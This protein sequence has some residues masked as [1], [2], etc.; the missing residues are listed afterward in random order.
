M[1]QRRI[2]LRLKIQIRELRIN[3]PEPGAANMFCLT[4]NHQ[5]KKARTFQFEEEKITIG[6]G[7]SCDLTI[8]DQSID[9]VQATITL[10]EDGYVLRNISPNPL[11]YLNYLPAL[12]TGLYP[13]DEIRV[14]K[15]LLLFETESVKE[16]EGSGRETVEIVPE[17]ELETTVGATLERNDSRLIS[18]EESGADGGKAAGA[19]EALYRVGLIIH[20]ITDTDL[21][22]DKLVNTLTEVT[23]ASRACFLA[24][25]DSGD[26]HPKSV[27]GREKK[28]AKILISRS[29]VNL[30]RDT[31]CGILCTNAKTDSRFRDS[32]SISLGKIRSAVCVP[33]E[34]KGVTFGLL[35]LDARGFTR[36]FTSFDEADLRLVK[37]IAG[38]AAL[39]LDYAQREMN[40]VRENITLK[41]ERQRR[42]GMVAAS[43]GM[44]KVMEVVGQLA[45]TDSTV[46]LRGET[47]S[48]K[49]VVARAIH[50]NS[51]RREMPLVT[52][53]CAA[54]PETLLQSELFGHEKGA[55][56]GAI[57]RRIGRFEQAA[58][59]TIFLDEIAELDPKSQVVL[60]R[61]LDDKLLQRLGGNKDIK[62]NIRIITATNRDLERLIEE[63]KFREDLYYR[64]KVLELFIPPLRERADDIEPLISFYLDYFTREGLRKVRE[65][66]PEALDELKKY[67]WPGNV[68]ELKNALERILVL[69]SSP[70]ITREDLYFIA[71]RRTPQPEETSIQELEREHIREVIKQARGNKKL[72]AEMLGI[73]RA[74]LYRKLKS[75]GISENDR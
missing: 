19:L 9:P 67:R 49:E 29:I 31:H 32:S 70:R 35:Y 39:A 63:G 5:K 59:G 74:T 30:V 21:L 1:R 18:R 71:S 52:V 66:D 60:L 62:V 20:G 22:L 34:W 45:P 15:T 56:T 73:N 64:L 33:V 38:Q 23:R 58:G 43:A 2:S 48:G 40:L 13:G 28:N 75:Y 10:E 57:G 26:F 46:L 12:E 4:V 51:K 65:I 14:G 36:E 16:R 17:E 11:T 42:F 55:F 7:S 41:R 3:K 53:N 61:I 54:F 47:G 69:G 25:D 50:L 8:P 24:R 72:A 6:R 37:A 68:R 27:F 44:K